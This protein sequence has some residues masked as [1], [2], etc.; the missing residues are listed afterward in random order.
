MLSVKYYTSGG[1]MW[2]IERTNRETQKEKERETERDR[3]TNR[4]RQ[5]ERKRESEREREWENERRRERERERHRETEGE[6]EREPERERQTSY[7]SYTLTN[8]SIIYSQNSRSYTLTGLSI[9]NSQSFGSKITQK[10][11][12][13]HA[14]FVQQINKNRSKF[15][16]KSIKLAFGPQEAPRA[17]KS[18]PRA[19]QDPKGTPIGHRLGEGFWAGFG[20]MLAPRTTLKPFKMHSK[21][22]LFLMSVFHQFFIDFGR[23]L[24]RFWAPCW[25]PTSIEK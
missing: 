2:N 7:T 20:A 13:N 17:P 15:N 11:F 23:V 16:H 12:K 22:S 14:K 10:S 4:K 1:C 5:R 9:Q 3:E 8:R 18:A 6:K 19:L 21:F 25:L 24:G